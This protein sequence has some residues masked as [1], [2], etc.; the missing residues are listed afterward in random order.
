MELRILT[1]EEL[2]IA[3]ETDLMEAF[4]PSELKPLS[5]MEEMRAQGIYDP[6]CLFDDAGDALGYL[7]LWKHRDGR[8]L[9]IDYLCVPARRR[10][11]GIGAKLLKMVFDAYPAQTVFL[12]ESE[13]PTGDAEA[14]EM[15]LR[16]LAFYARNNAVTLGYDCALFGVH[17]KTICWS[18][19]PLP[20][21]D[22]ILKKHR[23]IYLDVFG[24]EK[25]DRYIQ[26]PLGPG[27]KP[28]PVTDWVED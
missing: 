22:V 3:Y 6:L 10:N 19:E 14:D 23:E 1:P 9:L 11:G 16:R 24:Q 7:L 17:F 4:P 20:E 2:K 5:A 15:I 18:K 13:A 25:Y 27:E 8:F 21:E 28:Y 12:G 26:I